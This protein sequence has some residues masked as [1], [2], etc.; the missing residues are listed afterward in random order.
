MELPQFRILALASLGLQRVIVT[1][2]VI[3]LVLLCIGINIYQLS[4]LTTLFDNHCLCGLL[5]VGF[6]TPRQITKYLAIW[7]RAIN[8]PKWGI[9][10][11]SIKNVAQRR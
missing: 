6:S 9:P 8:M 5:P 4:L 11:R 2:K 7:L 3:D 1:S 10:E